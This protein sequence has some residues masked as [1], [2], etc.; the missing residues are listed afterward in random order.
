VGVRDLGL[1]VAEYPGA[2]GTSA[3]WGR[4]AQAHWCRSHNNAMN[5]TNRGVPG[6]KVGR[7]SGEPVLAEVGPPIMLSLDVA[8]YR[9]VSGPW[10]RR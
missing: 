8:G 10:M 7:A 2:G 9:S 3:A 6:F 5:Q 4:S 1:M